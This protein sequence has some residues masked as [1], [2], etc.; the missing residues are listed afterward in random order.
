MVEIGYEAALQPESE[1]AIGAALIAFN[2]AQVPQFAAPRTIGLTLRDPQTGQIDGGMTAR[3]SFNWLFI[4]MLV[5][6]ERLRGQGVGRQLMAQAE[7][8]AREAGCDGIWLD[9]FTF[10]APGFYAKLGY[11]VF[12]EITNYP[13]GASRY[14]LQKLL[15]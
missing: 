5:V 14:F 3:I 10:Q 7:T 4:E 2:R 8:V 11:S 12:G 9:T 6:P 15:S 13:P 1:A